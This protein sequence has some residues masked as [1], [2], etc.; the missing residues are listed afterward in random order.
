M[1]YFAGD[2][3][4][5]RERMLA[6]DYYIADDPVSGAIH[7]RARRLAD[8]YHRASLADE[9]A[10]YALLA[11]LVGELGEG[12]VVRSPLYVDYEKFR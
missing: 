7:T 12:V 2:S 11:E 4:T 9:T 3:R 5:N 6:G 8:A 10:A 1:D